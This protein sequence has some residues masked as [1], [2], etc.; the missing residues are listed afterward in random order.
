MKLSSG[1]MGL[2]ASGEK[3]A[4]GRRV[5]HERDGGGPLPALSCRLE[6]GQAPPPQGRSHGGQPLS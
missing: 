6:E 4:N 2:R 5:L 3:K 1:A